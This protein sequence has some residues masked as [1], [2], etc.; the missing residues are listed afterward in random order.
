MG[1]YK[2]PET[3]EMLT[4]EQMKQINPDYRV[5]RGVTDSIT[6]GADEFGGDPYPNKM[7]Q[8]YCDTNPSN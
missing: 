1:L 4:F 7:K 8:C 2:K 5:V 6:C 3:D